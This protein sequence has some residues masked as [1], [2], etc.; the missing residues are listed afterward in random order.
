MKQAI[1]PRNFTRQT[2]EPEAAYRQAMSEFQW[3]EST[4]KRAAHRRQ[5][6]RA[7]RGLWHGL[8]GGAAIWL[9]VLAAFKLLPLPGW[10][11]PAAGGVAVLLSAGGFLLGLLRRPTLA[12]TARWI[13]RGQHLQER[14]S[15]ALE[16]AGAPGSGPWRDLVVNDAA[17]HAKRLEVNR[18]VP[19]RLPAVSRWALIILALSAGLGFVPEYR[20]KAYLQKRREAEIIRDTGKQMAELVRRT[21][22][23]RPPAME[24]TRKSMETVAELGDQLNQAKLTRADALK[25]LASITE[26]LQKETKELGQNPALKK[27][28]QAARTPAG[29]TD[30]AN[31]GALQ[32][33]IESLQKALNSQA[34]NPEALQKLKKELQQLKEAAAGMS[35]KDGAEG[36]AAREQLAKS[37][38]SLSQQAKNLGASLPSLEAAIEALQAS[39]PDLFLR[40]LNIA[41]NDL[42]K[43]KELAK[44]LQQ[45]QQQAEKLGQDLAEQLKYGQ[46]EAAQTTLQKMIDQLKTANLTPDQL[47]KLLD[48]VQKAVDPASQYGKVA[49][50]LSQATKQM[51]QG[52]KPGAAKSLAD[53]ADELKKLMEQMGDAQSLAGTLEALQRAQMCIGNC[54]GWAQCKYG[55]P[56]FRPGGKPGKGVGTWADETGWLF[57]PEVT[58][59]WDN[60]GIERPDM[61]PRGHTDRG[62]GQVADNADPT[63]IRGQFSP[64]GS[65]PSITLKGVS[66]KGQSVVGYQE[67][68]M[69]A[70]QEAQSAL[71]QERVPRAYQGAVKDYFDDLKE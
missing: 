29:K 25:E 10:L 48:E 24:Q 15:T 22:E 33:Q 64:G 5:W 55:R 35:S 49:E 12:E 38:A 18:L 60:S 27:L 4:L 69:A 52:Q 14:L 54:Q 71:S 40:E 45:L 41:L 67:A 47:Q 58:E 43:M 16:V 31:S 28:E 62:D 1:W 37:L 30:P 66:I 32:K 70:Q 9:F 13:D 36:A 19:W 2:H 39:Q 51:Q 61:D 34:G 59:R 6:E 65:M 42:E 7:W 68:V 63:K 26:K 56:G 3:I 44:S 17:E 46:T 11:L 21:L 53:A 57:E 8:L 50:Y 20:S 23:Q